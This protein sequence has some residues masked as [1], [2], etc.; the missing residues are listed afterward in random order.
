MDSSRDAAE[1]SGQAPVSTDELHGVARSAGVVGG[2][3]LASRVLGLARDVVLASTF[4]PMATD[5]FFVAFMIPNLLRRLVGEGSLTISFVPVFTTWFQRSR[6]EARRVFNATWT[7]TALVGAALTALGMLFADPLI[8]LFA[9]GFALEP[10]K[11]ELAVQLL[12]LCFP[13]I[14]C[15]MLV[16]VAMGALNALGHFLAPAIAPVLLNLCLIAGA[17]SGALWFDPPILALGAAVIAAGL[18]QV[19][20][21]IA[22]LS[23]RGVAPRPLLR[24]GHPA[25]RR[26]AVLM[27][28]A[29]L[30]A[31]VFQINLLVS[32]FLSSFLGDGAVSYLYYADRLL[33]LPLGIFIFALGTASLPSFARLAKGS[34]R[35][36]L[37]AAFEGTL[38]LA[39]ALALPAAAGLVLLRQPLFAQLFAWNPSTFGAAAVEGCAAA[40]LFYACGLVPIAVARVA[41]MLSVANE[42]TRIPARGAVVGVL[43]NLLAA[44]A[45]IG[46]L[47]AGKLPLWFTSLQHAMVLAELSYPG[48]ALAAS[49]A[50]AANAAYVWLALRRRYGG[51]VRRTFVGRVVRIVA[52]TA[53]MS[54]VVL[55]ATHLWPVPE[56][57]SAIGV[58]LLILHAGLGVLSYALAL[59]ALRSPEV[60]P[61]VR[62]FRRTQ[63]S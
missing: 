49:I 19:L 38:T 22:P 41:V 25:L 52:A 18:L 28:P 36:A 2:A 15:L 20:L 8:H 46:P 27:G 31:S 40:L 3:T 33:E 48:L 63:V 47:P 37:S 29:A 16:A 34:D 53:L 44:L 45:L 58:G 51:L 12:R 17:V 61:L 59:V 7:L 30:G 1:Y 23:Q 11:H 43:V 56:T 14:L 5:A 35:E 57:A 4:L 26:L 55:G 10:G 54:L 39:T 9:P 6:E 62:L 60:A 32:R 42:D 21:Q 24:F 50:A 13:Y